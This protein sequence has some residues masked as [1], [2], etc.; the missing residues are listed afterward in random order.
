MCLPHCVPHC[1]PH[2]CLPHCVSLTVSPRYNYV[3]PTSYLE[4]ISTFKTLLSEKRTEVALAKNRYLVGLEKLNSSSE[5]VAGM[6]TELTALMPELKVTVTQVRPTPGVDFVLTMHRRPVCAVT[7]SRMHEAPRA[8]V[9]LWL[10][11][12]YCA[13]V[14]SVR[15]YLTGVLCVDQVEGMMV[16]IDKEKVEVVEPKKA[17][18][19][20]EEAIAAEQAAAAKAIKEECEEALGEAMPALQVGDRA[21]V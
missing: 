15:L 1:V 4:L 10:P 12:K 6:Q 9:V 16:Q 13:P 21:S 18:V 8:I 19:Q 17:I 5:Q 2:L 3:T 14:S 11:R 20:K 7:L